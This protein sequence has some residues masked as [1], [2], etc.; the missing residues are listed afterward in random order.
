MGA[1]VS[2]R[3]AGTA[4]A[5]GDVE[6]TFI[7][8]GYSVAVSHRFPRR[9]AASP[10]ALSAF[11]RTRE[12]GRE[13][14]TREGGRGREKGDADTSRN[15]GHFAKPRTLRETSSPAGVTA[16]LAALDVAEPRARFPAHDRPLG[17][18]GPAERRATADAPR[19]GKRKDR[20]RRRS[21]GR[22]TRG[23]QGHRW[24]AALPFAVQTTATRSVPRQPAARAAVTS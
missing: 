21:P 13:K 4:A 10:I 20:R 6:R 15:R 3:T 7:K 9:F 23:N 11:G 12:G 14:G 5:S 16:M 2:S 24:S 18:T 1:M 22:L 19:A 8:P 17:E